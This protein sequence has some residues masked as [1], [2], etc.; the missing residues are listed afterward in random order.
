M[1]GNVWNRQQ[2]TTALTRGEAAVRENT[3][4]RHGWLRA[5][6]SAVQVGDLPGRHN[7]GRRRVGRLLAVMRE[8]RGTGSPSGTMAHHLFRS[9]GATAGVPAD[10]E[11]AAALLFCGMIRAPRRA[12]SSPRQPSGE[13]ERRDAGAAALLREERWRGGDARMHRAGKG[14]DKPL[15]PL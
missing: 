11:S 15:Q 14:G 2:E 8:R 3:R 13:E 7:N 9:T 12:E 6:R 1:R 4:R 5:V 10:S